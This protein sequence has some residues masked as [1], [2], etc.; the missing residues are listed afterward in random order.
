MRLPSL[1]VLLL[2]GITL[3][4]YTKS[5]REGEQSVQ[6]SAPHVMRVP[7]WNEQQAADW[8]KAKDEMYANLQNSELSPSQRCEK[9][10]NITWQLSKAGNLEA[11]YAVFNA[12]REGLALGFEGDR[13]FLVSPMSISTYLYYHSLGAPSLTAEITYM[14]TRLDTNPAAIND[15]PEQAA[16][17][18]YPKI[19][20]CVWEHP[21]QACTE[22]I[23]YLMPTFERVAAEL[24]MLAAGKVSMPCINPNNPNNNNPN[25]RPI[26][27]E[28]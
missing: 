27:R 18:H 4:G 11:R 9:S 19:R 6:P 1:L 8:Q 7:D 3:T 20:A 24:D 26:I 16:T 17:E 10:W 25:I 23:G 14:R 21:S 2:A 5:I 13:A 12:F 28:R 22:M 15:Y